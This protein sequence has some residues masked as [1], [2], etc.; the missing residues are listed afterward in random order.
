MTR[1]AASLVRDFFLAP[2]RVVRPERPAPVA[3][4]VVV[5]GDARVVPALACAAALEL[6]RAGGRDHA[7]ALLWPGAGAPSTRVPATGPA[8]RGAARIAARGCEADAT[9]RLVR[10]R[11]PDDPADATATVQRVV[12]GADCP[13]AVGLGGPRTPELDTLFTLADAVVLTRRP[14]EAPALTRLAEAGLARLQVPVVTC[15]ARLG[16]PG[17]LL[18]TTGLAAV[19][20]RSG[21]GL[22]S[23]LRSDRSDQSK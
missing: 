1:S 5:L 7:A 17:R 15:E 18:A 19:W 22:P 21:T 8:R 2:E 20:G 3:P 9:G 10:A 4:V 12:G 23:G 6:V 13:V 11:L 14:G 16:A